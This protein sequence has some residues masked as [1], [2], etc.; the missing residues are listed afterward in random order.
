[1]LKIELKFK[2]KILKQFETDKSE[3]TI[4]RGNNN[5][6]QIDNL[7]VSKTHARIIKGPHAYM[8]EDLNST[9]GTFLNDEPIQKA[10]LTARDVLTIGKH[11]L[12]FASTDDA[13]SAVEDLAD[14]TIKVS[15]AK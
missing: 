13:L 7:G 2:G 9:N 8:V 10:N 1:M 4:G 5:D 15:S 12:S 11:T 3:I 14:K 6:I